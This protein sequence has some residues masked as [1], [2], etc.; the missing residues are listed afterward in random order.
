MLIDDVMER[1]YRLPDLDFGRKGLAAARDYWTMNALLEVHKG[2]ILDAQSVK[3]FLYQKVPGDDP[4]ETYA[5]QYLHNQMPPSQTCWL[6]WPHGG[7]K[8]GVLVDACPFLEGFFEGVPGV[9]NWAKKEEAAYML[10]LQSFF[11]RKHEMY[12]LEILQWIFLGADGRLILNERGGL[13]LV[14]G[15][16]S[17]YD[18][19]MVDHL[20]ELASIVLFTFAFMSIKNVVRREHTAPPKLQAR[21]VKKGK[22]PLVK[23]H[24]LEIEVPGKRYA[25][26]KQSGSAP[27]R[28]TPLHLVR[29]HIAD[30]RNGR[31]LFGKHRGIFY[32]PAH[33]RGDADHGVIEKRYR[34]VTHD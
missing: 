25:D 29:G 24:T 19:N 23:Y 1:L 7:G 6:E 30:Y 17:R 32:V 18:E 26:G 8:L 34:T 11:G 4:I 27:G 16:L 31:G 13:A 21:R 15:D 33:M 14:E 10:R 28:S 12:E 5:L 22:R 20:S 3:D 2:V 9:S